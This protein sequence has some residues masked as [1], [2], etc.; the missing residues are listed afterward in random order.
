VS[1]LA[2][3]GAESGSVNGDGDIQPSTSDPGI[4]A[5]VFRSGKYAYK[6]TASLQ[7]MRALFPAVEARWYY[8][9]TWYR[10]DALPTVAVRILTWHA[11][12]NSSAT[13]NL[14]M[15][16]PSGQLSYQ[17]P[18]TPTLSPAVS[19]NTWFC[20]EYA[21]RGRL[22]VGY[23]MIFRLDGVTLGTGFSSTALTTVGLPDAIRVGPA[24]ISAPMTALWMDDIAVNDDTGAA[25]NGFPG[26][27]G[28]IIHLAAIA[29]SAVGADWKSNA[30]TAFSPGAYDCFDNRPPTPN[31]FGGGG[32][33][34]QARNNVSN[35]AAPAADL[36][37]TTAVYS[38]VLAPTDVVRVCQHR[39]V[40]GDS[41]AT[42]QYQV[43]GQTTSNPAEATET[44]YTTRAIAA[45]TDLTNTWLRV[46]GPVNYS[47]V[48]NKANGAVLR[49]GKRSATTDSVGCCYAALQVEYAPPTTTAQRFLAVA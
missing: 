33:Q 14:V 13:S 12:G 20:V 17:G 46:V 41:H 10:V 8:A 43:A 29:D 26:I 32:A 28:K 38:S 36:D 4:D 22:G 27:D 25:Q 40:L 45:T 6:A 11:N 49:V 16:Q 44:T 5:T 7:N 21:L 35:V 48:V 39:M 3:A 24:S 18:T 1:R 19:V 2:W 30:L 15:L 9:R 31:S 37:V 23:D 42:A 34:V 47:P